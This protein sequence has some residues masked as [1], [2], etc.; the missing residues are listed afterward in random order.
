MKLAFDLLSD[1]NAAH[2]YVLVG[3]LGDAETHRPGCFEPFMELAVE[4]G[5]NLKLSIYPTKSS[6]SLT[7]EQWEEIAQKAR[8]YH[9]RM[10]AGGEEW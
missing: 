9:A 5:D 7:V 1:V 8:R 10:L 3:L 2:P 4:K 6:V